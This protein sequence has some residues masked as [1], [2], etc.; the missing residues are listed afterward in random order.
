MS[1]S[2]SGEAIREMTKK[3]AFQYKTNLQ[4]KGVLVENETEKVDLCESFQASEKWL[5][6]LKKRLQLR[7]IRL[8]G[9]AGS[10]NVD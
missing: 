8:V 9:E 7:S 2:T 6:G 5:E 1:Y 4:A 3:L 10:A